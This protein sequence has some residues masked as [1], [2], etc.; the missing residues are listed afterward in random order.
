MAEREQV[1]P[2]PNAK[3]GTIVELLQKLRILGGSRDRRGLASALGVKGRSAYSSI[4]AAQMLGLIDVDEQQVTLNETGST[5]LDSDETGRK[6]IFG[7][8][9]RGIEPFATI[10]R[11]LEQGPLT[12]EQLMN[13]VRAWIPS[14]RQ[15]KDTTIREML[16]TIRGWCLYGSLLVYDQESDKYLKPS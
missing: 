12:G 4:H 10:A 9:L 1:E 11:A 16:K 3:V 15:W 2:I 5:L 8:Q 13:Y 7:E 6:R 14:A